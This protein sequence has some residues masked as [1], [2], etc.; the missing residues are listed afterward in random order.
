MH[1]LIFYHGEIVGCCYNLIKS[2]VSNPAISVPINKQNN[3][4]IEYLC[5]YNEPEGPVPAAAINP[6]SDSA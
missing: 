2:K 5:Q 3:K 1:N 4:F 6:D